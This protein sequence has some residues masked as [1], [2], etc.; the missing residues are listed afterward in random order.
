MRDRDFERPERRPK[1]H[2]TF[3]ALETGIDPAGGE[4]RGGALWRSAD[5]AQSFKAALEERG[6]RSRAR[7]PARFCHH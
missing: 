1:K 4:S 3:R 6:E 7:R 2:E 5:N